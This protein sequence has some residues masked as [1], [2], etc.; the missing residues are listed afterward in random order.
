MTDENALAARLCQLII[1]SSNYEGTGWEGI[2]VICDVYKS[3][4][5]NVT[6]YY[7]TSDPGADRPWQVQTPD[8]SREFLDLLRALNAA[9]LERTGAR[10]KS[11]LVQIVRDGMSFA[12]DFEYD[13]DDRWD[14][15][16]GTPARKGFPMTIN[17]L[18]SGV[19]D[20][21]KDR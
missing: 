7:F 10:W 2:S 16:P 18:V 9:M 8:S 11:C 5:T 21:A 19:A 17:P 4:S 1:K 12:I 6:G 14:P 15:M 3:G 20:G 13:R